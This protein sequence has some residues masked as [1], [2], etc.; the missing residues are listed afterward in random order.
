MS[1]LEEFHKYRDEYGMNQLRS[2]G[3]SGIVTQNGQLFTLEFAMIVLESDEVSVEEAVAEIIRL[4]Q[5]YGSLE[6]MMGTSL[7]EP[8][9]LEGN[10][11]DNNGAHLVFSA[12]FDGGGYAKRMWEVGETVQ[13]VG[14]DFEQDPLTNMQYF[15]LARI[16][17]ATQMIYRPWR[18][19]GWAKSKFGPKYFWNNTRPGEFALWGWYGRSP[20]F[21]G[22]LDM[23]AGK[24]STVF[25]WASILIG[26]FVGCFAPV[27]NT[28]ARKLPYVS[29]YY[30][31]RGTPWHSRWF[32]K[33]M[34]RIWVKI[35]LLDYSGGMLDV[36][37]IYYGDPEHPIHRY[38][39]R[40]FEP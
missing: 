9:S 1:L 19:L 20:G 33:L 11:M 4:R 2:D 23:T 12:L 36:Y 22:L 37:A 35:L 16:I 30:L 28:D 3:T 26:Q 32:W 40:Y 27:G 31:V 24:W 15:D 18:W 39:E 34:Y 13:C 5:V 14:P 25:R 6:Y 8:N 38:A 17:T 10:S 7:R 29:W 21:L